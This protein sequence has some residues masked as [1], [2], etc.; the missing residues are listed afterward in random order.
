M[1]TITRKRAKEAL[2]NDLMNV[3]LD[4]QVFDQ[5]QYDFSTPRLQQLGSLV[6]AGKV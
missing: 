2:K 4:T 5:F 3:F 6:K 1:S